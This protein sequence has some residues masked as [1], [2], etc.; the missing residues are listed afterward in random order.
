MNVIRYSALQY[1]HDDSLTHLWHVEREG[2]HYL[3]YFKGG[4]TLSYDAKSA[5][6]EVEIAS[7]FDKEL[8]RQE[9]GTYHNEVWKVTTETMDSKA[10]EILN[11]FEH[12]T[13]GV[14]WDKAGG[15][16]SDEAQFCDMLEKQVD[17][18]KGTAHSLP[19]AKHPY[20]PTFHNMVK[21]A[22]AD[23]FGASVRLYRGIH[24]EQAIPILNGEPVK[25]RSV[26]SWTSDL[27]GARVYAA[28]KTKHGG[29]DWVVVQR[30]F[31]PE[32]IALAPVTLDGPCEN[33]DI[34]MRLMYDVEHSGDEFIV[35]LRE[36]VPGDYKIAAKP[37]GKTT[38]SILRKYVRTLL[39]EQAGNDNLIV[40]DVQPEYEGN[41]PFDIGDL[42]RVA[43]GYNRVLFL[44]N[45]PDLGMIDEGSLKNYYLEKLDWDE[46]AFNDLMSGASFFDKGYGF[47]RDVMDSSICFPRQD[48]VK[49]VK[50]MIDNDHRDIRD[51]EE[52]DIDTLGISDL[53]YDDL[54]DYGFYVPD[55]EEELPRWSGSDIAGGARN[56]CLAEV[57]ILGSALGLSFNQV[58]SF[59]YEGDTR[60]TEE[61]LVETF[62]H[63][64]TSDYFRVDMHNIGY[65]QGG[66]QLRFKACQS[67]VDKI[68]QSPEYL[69]AEERY[70]SNPKNV[71][72]DGSLKK[73]TPRF[74]D[75]DNAWINNP[76]NRGKGHGKEIYT[77][78]INKAIEYSK[79]YGG[80]FIGAH[81][82]T[83]GS[84]TSQAAKRVWKSLT[85]EYTSSGDVI[86]I[87]L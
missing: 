38:E 82:C 17:T 77:A 32:E 33:P 87:G 53:L 48:I 25:N 39:T 64:G 20:W 26:S 24:G 3:L 43:A 49:I 79:S 28:G 71:W 70:L 45:G 31:S 69:E 66:Q 61:V 56:E 14:D 4:G 59:I 35:N 52:E 12:P 8:A 81:H 83:I 73:F 74:Y 75:V 62:H 2:I 6:T 67:D 21:N 11:I 65:A 19:V 86:F 9:S 51:L 58:D 44:Y 41:T 50:Y 34:L 27:Q 5:G 10:E 36:L 76:K 23:E 7:A 60:Y 84:G 15:S 29:K 46:E 68:K 85:R 22:V 55:L 42:L 57:E 37:R 78:F 80:V 13:W 40:V 54:E 1:E 72:G 63:K 47:F 30:N 18:W 16:I